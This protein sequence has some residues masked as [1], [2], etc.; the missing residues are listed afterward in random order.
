MPPRYD[1]QGLK[2]AIK[3]LKKTDKSIRLSDYKTAKA[4]VAFLQSRNYPV[5]GLTKAS[6]KKMSKPESQFKG[7]S[8]I[9]ALNIGQSRTPYAEALYGKRK[10]MTATRAEKKMMSAGKKEAKALE[11]AQRKA[12]REAKK[13]AKEELKALKKAEREAKKLAKK[14]A[15]KQARKN[16]KKPKTA[17][18]GTQ[19]DLGFYPMSSFSQVGMKR[20]RL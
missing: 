19:T 17:E 13:R 6:A 16:A 11:V 1:K 15:R 2:D 10:P 9:G 20:Q 14:E 3:T 5:A 12:D 8:F 7:A 18:M 4:M